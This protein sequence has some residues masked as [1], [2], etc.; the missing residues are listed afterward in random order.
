MRP[1]N[2]PPSMRQLDYLRSLAQRTGT[3]FA[4]PRTRSQASREIQRLKRLPMLRSERGEEAAA[5][6][7]D[8]ERLTP[9]SAVRP[10]EGARATWAGHG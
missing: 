2:Q 8:R 10:E 1:S 7:D 5:R 3:T 9:S 4:Y 6:G